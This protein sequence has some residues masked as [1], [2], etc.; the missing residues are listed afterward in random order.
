MLLIDAGAPPD[1]PPPRREPWLVSL[2]LDHLMPWPALVVWLLAA[3]VM[4]DGW[5]GVLCSWAAV[6]V[7]FWRM[8][9]AFAGVGGLRDHMQ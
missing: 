8:S 4:T 3:A 6:L 2:V 7:A 5:P 1:P 9:R